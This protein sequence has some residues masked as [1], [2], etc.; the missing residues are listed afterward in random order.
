[1]E[2]DP[3]LPRPAAPDPLSAPMDASLNPH[4]HDRKKSPIEKPN[5]EL[6]PKPA[7]QEQSSQ[8]ATRAQRDSDEPD[9]LGHKVLNPPTPYL[10]QNLMSH[11]N[12]Q[13]LVSS[14][15][16]TDP[17]TGEKINKMRKSYEGKV[18]ALGLAGRNRAVKHQSGKAMGL[19]EMAQW[20]EEEWINQKVHGRQVQAGLADATLAKL[21][22][23]MQMQP[24]PVPNTNEYDWDDL[25][26]TEKIK[27]LPTVEERSKKALSADPS[28]TKVN[29]QVNG[30][31]VPANAV[32]ATELTRPKRAGK[33]RRYDED[34]FEGYGEGYNDDI[35]DRQTHASGYSSG[36]NSR[37]GSSAKK[38]R[39]ESAPASSAPLGDRRGSYGIGMIG[40][41][42]GVG[43][44]GR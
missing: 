7:A 19:L 11:F 6:P 35:E 18:K 34:S 42:T 16:R 38:R 10:Q 24:G 30:A 39:K 28:K 33:K 20:P 36:E 12:L 29:G 21:D 5:N 25:L 2:I 14:V 26:G 27:P 13:S 4:H 1:M 40:I 37:T 15:A 22:K 9:L 31:H 23:A 8:G 44:Y 32:A 17:V 41:G 3:D 43:A